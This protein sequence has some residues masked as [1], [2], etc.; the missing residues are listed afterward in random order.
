MP[1]PWQAENVHGSHRYHKWS[2]SKVKLTES[3]IIFH[4]PRFGRGCTIILSPQLET[5]ALYQALLP[6]IVLKSV[7]F[8]P[9]A[10]LSSAGCCYW[11]YI[12]VYI[13]TSFCWSEYRNF[14]CLSFHLTLHKSTLHPRADLKF[15][16]M[17]L[18][19]HSFCLQWIL[20]V[21]CSHTW[22]WIQFLLTSDFL[23]CISIS[24]LQ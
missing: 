6:L 2:T 24:I 20:F 1:G 22:A 18:F 3:W 5:W 4:F 13:L 9:P 16:T 17:N 23:Y 21:Q 12:L 8:L 7:L 19:F 14:I 11:C 15:V 10:L